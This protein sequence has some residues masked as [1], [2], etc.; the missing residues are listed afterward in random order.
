MIK[1]NKI[2]RIHKVVNLMRMITGCTTMILV[3]RI[4]QL[5]NINRFGIITPRDEDR[6]G[7]S[8]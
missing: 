8:E 3:K 5:T 2:T 7:V 6:V 1:I 4:L